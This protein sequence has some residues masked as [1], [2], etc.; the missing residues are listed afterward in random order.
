MNSTVEIQLR[1]A[2]ETLQLLPRAVRKDSAQVASILTT[3]LSNISFG[4]P[5]TI[6]VP[7]ARQFEL[8]AERLECLRLRLRIAVPANADDDEPAAFVNRSHHETRICLTKMSAALKTVETMLPFLFA[9]SAPLEIFEKYGSA[10]TAVQTSLETDPASMAFRFG[11]LLVV[12]DAVPPPSDEQM[13]KILEAAQAQGLLPADR[14]IGLPDYRSKVIKKDL[15]EKSK[16]PRLLLE[17][18]TREKLKSVAEAL[19]WSETELANQLLQAHATNSKAVQSVIEFRLRGQIIQSL[20]AGI[21]TARGFIDE[22]ALRRYECDSGSAHGVRLTVFGNYALN[23]EARAHKLL[24]IFAGSSWVFSEDF[25]RAL[26][27]LLPKVQQHLPPEAEITGPL[28]AMTDYL[29]LLKIL[30]TTASITTTPENETAH[31]E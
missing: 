10:S 21:Q 5:M 7:A 1:L 12:M 13:A 2:D 28:K 20:L 26:D 30:P 19:E 6:L 24:P 22:A 9:G 14:M 29:R 8:L 11:L 25:L 3:A 18:A 31:Q 27:P 15:A 17:E 4:F 23:L 16:K